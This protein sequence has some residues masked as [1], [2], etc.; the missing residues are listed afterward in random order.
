MRLFFQRSLLSI[1]FFSMAS[2]V[3]AQGLPANALLEA[4]P[5]QATSEDLYSCRGV[6]VP[7]AIALEMHY[8]GQK[9]LR[10]YL[11]EVSLR[12]GSDSTAAHLRTVGVQNVVYPTQPLIMP[13][14]KWRSV[15][16]GIPDGVQ[17]ADI[18]AV[19]V[20]VLAFDD[21]TIAGP[22]DSRASRD[23]LGQLYGIGFA[24]GKGGSEEQL[25]APVKGNLELANGEGQEKYDSG[26]L[27]F[28]SEIE[29]NSDSPM[30]AVKVTNTGSVPVRAC[31]FKTSFFDAS[32]GSLIR[33]VTTEIVETHGVASDYLAPGASWLAPA[34]KIPVSSGGVP[35]YKF[36]LDMVVF[37]N[38]RT[39]GPQRSTSSA[40]VT[41]MIK[42]MQ[43]AR[44]FKE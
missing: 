7:N 22:A 24:T 5:S 40:E 2:F 14:A 43:L 20:D 36:S 11:V 19:K 29:H 6:S 41:G 12:V 37:V 16:C 25:V 32:T 33:S 42:G 21:G 39:Y 35:V 23:I 9:A 44:N 34:R 26:P 4:T 17:L 13:G 8:R 3:A 18:A 31:V 38:G 28:S 27:A 10:G 1:A 15:I 30:L